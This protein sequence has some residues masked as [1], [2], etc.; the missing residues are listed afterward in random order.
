MYSHDDLSR[1]ASA[2][3]GSVLSQTF[4][5]DAF[6]NIKKNGT[7]CFQ[8]IY[9]TATNH[10][11]LSGVTV[12]YDTAGNILNDGT[13][14]FAWD[15]FGKPITV[16]GHG[17]TYDAFGDMVEADYPSEFFDSPDGS[18]QLTATPTIWAAFVSTPPTCSLS[19]KKFAG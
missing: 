16:R 2:N 7:Y 4:G 19:F 14:T 12:S 5:Y 18:A 9:N 3:C 11:I 6:G 8:P 13:N 10:Y 1:I 15:A 17:V